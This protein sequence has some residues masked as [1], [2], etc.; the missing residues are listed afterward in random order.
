MR[1]ALQ[2]LLRLCLLLLF[3]CMFQIP[4]KSNPQRGPVDDTFKL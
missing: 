4:L 1:P 3:F 2:L